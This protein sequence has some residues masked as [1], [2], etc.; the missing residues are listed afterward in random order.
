MGL[1]DKVKS[2]YSDYKKTREEERNRKDKLRQDPR[3][4]ASLQAEAILRQ[5]R[6]QRRWAAAAA[7]GGAGLAVG[8]AVTAAG[9]QT[10]ARAYRLGNKWFSA[11]DI[12]AIFA[13]FWYLSTEY[14]RK[15][16]LNTLGGNAI[17]A[18]IVYIAVISYSEKGPK[19][20]GVLAGIVVWETANFLIAY[21]FPFIAQFPAYRDYIGN[22]MFTLVWVYYALIKGP[23][24]F[25]H[26]LI[27][28]L[29][30]LM[31]IG[32]VLFFL[33][34]VYPLEQI[35]APISQ[36][37]QSSAINIYKKGYEWSKKIVLNFPKIIR[38]GKLV[39]IQ[40][41]NLATGGV[42]ASSVDAKQSE[43]LGVRLKQ[44]KPNDQQ[45]WT[46]DTVSASGILEAKTLEDGIKIDLACYQGGKNKDG[47]FPDSS[48]G[49]MFPST[50]PSVYDEEKLDV[51]CRVNALPEGS[52]RV[53]VQADFNFETMAYLKTYFMD[54]ERMRGLVRAGLD[55]LEEFLITDKT[56]ISKFTQGP[57]QVGIG[58]ITP[59]VGISDNQ[60]TIRLGVSLSTNTGWRGKIKEMTGLQILVPDSLSL[61]TEECPEFEEIT[62]VYVE[63]C[64][65][66][67]MVYR[68]QTYHSCLAK[69]GISRDVVTVL[70]STQQ[71][72][73]D[74]CISDYCKEEI[75]GYKAYNLSIKNKLFYS[76]IGYDSTDRQSKSFS[77]RVKV[78][79]PQKLLG[80]VPVS[81]QYFRAK[82]RY[83]Y[84]IEEST[85]V[86]VKASPIPPELGTIPKPPPPERIGDQ[87][88][89]I[90]QQYGSGDAASI[91]KYCK[92]SGLLSDEL[93]CYCLVTSIMARESG[94]DRTKIGQAGEVSLMQITPNASKEAWKLTTAC[95][96]LTDPDCNIK[97]SVYY[98]KTF[99][100]NEKIAQP[101]I[102]SEFL[103]NTVT[104]YMA[105]YNCGPKALWSTANCDGKLNWECPAEKNTLKDRCRWNNQDST[106]ITYVPFVLLRYDYCMNAK[107]PTTAVWQTPTDE[108]N[109]FKDGPAI[110]ISDMETTMSLVGDNAVWKAPVLKALDPPYSLSI[111]KYGK[112]DIRVAVMYGKTDVKK[113]TVSSSIQVRESE[114]FDSFDPN[115][116]AIRFGLSGGSLNSRYL[117]KVAS[118]E[119]TLIKNNKM[120]D[121]KVDQEVF[122]DWITAWYG[123]DNYIYLYAKGQTVSFCRVPWSTYEQRSAGTCEQAKHL[124]WKIVNK[125]T[126]DK[127]NM[128]GTIDVQESATI[129]V[130]FDPGMQ[131]SCCGDCSCS[132]L[133]DKSVFCNSCDTSS[134][135]KMAV[136]AYG[137]GETSCAK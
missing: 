136:G 68:T 117:Q 21:Y 121:L 46:G 119:T 77:C 25:F 107:L 100:K 87:V 32:I 66:N 75:S 51:E 30:V 45:Y 54:Q 26:K 81:I 112:D 56:P 97:A 33:S 24:T 69:Q 53:T 11:Y 85:T 20:I 5:Q 62:G 90:F 6:S 39:F 22:P 98:L 55:P 80:N 94:G 49:I 50:I 105:A 120:G 84:E 57:V 128:Y 70:D 122:K 133:P 47:F 9:R 3:Y 131:H 93:K 91:Q 42:Y 101:P 27:I 1:F 52:H 40:Q 43:T 37:A 34:Q 31:W 89:Y 72:A 125:K 38:Q 59:P 73:V 116:P 19:T 17:I 71:A 102:G 134:G 74:Q 64:R 103:K 13:I 123:P 36:Q 61:A 86:T 8:S 23:P 115:Y 76:N 14:W 44:F 29:I 58:G 129:Q 127:S 135:C 78:D 96:P 132:K 65:K 79:S 67:H 109:I 12:F 82:T 2:G 18:V 92:E 4:Q 88:A 113:D 63:D 124:G 99:E 83:V 108:A 137:Y 7:V 110:S 60:N 28:F 10:A 104:N 15:S 48:K 111:N 95:T 35:G 41:M 114:M 16:L 106:R 118:Q 130:Q 126:V